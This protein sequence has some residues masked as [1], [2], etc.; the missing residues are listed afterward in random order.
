VTYPIAR[1]L[2]LKKLEIILTV[3]VGEFV[4]R[5]HPGRVYR[6]AFVKSISQYKLICQFYTVWTHWVLFLLVN[7]VC[8]ND[9]SPY[10]FPSTVVHTHSV[11]IVSHIFWMIVRNPLLEM[12]LDL[13]AWKSRR[14]V[15]WVT[16][17][18]DIWLWLRK[19]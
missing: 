4:L 3:I 14:G 17:L 19:R 16:N 9:L 13:S 10:Q 5:S 11:M 15:Q 7:M 6:H 18:D 12:A 8:Y 2:P 1:H